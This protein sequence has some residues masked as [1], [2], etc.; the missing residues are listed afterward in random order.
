MAHMFQAHGFTRTAATSP[1]VTWAVA[2][3][4]QREQQEDMKTRKRLTC[5][6]HGHACGGGGQKV[7][8]PHPLPDAQSPICQGPVFLA[9]AGD[10]PWTWNEIYRQLSFE[11]VDIV[12]VLDVES[13]LF[14][15]VRCHTSP[16]FKQ[17]FVRR[18][19]GACEKT[20]I[21]TLVSFRPCLSPPNLR[22]RP[23]F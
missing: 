15:A 20:L 4:P 7:K 18:E 3:P 2:R 16:V 17:L 1:Q 23:P 13:L 12:S 9:S 22:D 6:R 14:L 19:L 11:A 10:C 21:A 8:C 5:G